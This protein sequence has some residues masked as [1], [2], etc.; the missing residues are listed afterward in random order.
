[1]TTSENTMKRF[2]TVALVTGLTLLMAGQAFA[3]RTRINSLSGQE[4][5]YTIKDQSNIFVFP[6]TMVEYGNQV[7]IDAVSGSRYGTMNVRYSLTD[8]AVLLLFGHSSPWVPVVHKGTLGGVDQNQKPIA[9]VNAASVSGFAQKAIDPTNH[10]F[11][12]GFGTRIGEAARIGGTFSMGG[13]NR[14]RD[15]NWTHDNTWIDLDVGFG[16]DIGETDSLE[17]GLSIGIGSFTNVESSERYV[18]AGLFNIGLLARGVFSV[19]QIASIVPYLGFI[20][21]GRAIEHQPTNACGGQPQDCASLKGNTAN[22]DVRLGT[23]LAIRPA[24]GVLVQPGIGLTIQSAVGEGNLTPTANSPILTQEESVFITPHYGFAA[25]AAVF[26]W[27]LLRVGA[28]QS[29][30]VSNNTNTIPPPAGGVPPGTPPPSNERHWSDVVNTV[31]TGFGIQMRG[32]TLDLNVN[33]SFFNNNVFAISGVATSPFAVD[34]AMVY[35]W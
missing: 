5:G 33:P 11:G 8:D 12:I 9:G 31:T 29:I 7:D 4:K 3:T 26:D 34:F 2:M 15:G 6:Q 30:V 32:W 10:Q 20:Y 22:T 13:N 28:R 16:L 35:D 17:L 14:T 19:H 23:D 25:E 21:D 24:E 1:M 18:G 27:L